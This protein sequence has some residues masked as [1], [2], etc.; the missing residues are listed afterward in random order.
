MDDSSRSLDPT[1]L[2][3]RT[4]TQVFDFFSDATSNFL[5]ID[6]SWGNLLSR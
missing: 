3:P 6:E 1:D 4:F 2:L 5:K